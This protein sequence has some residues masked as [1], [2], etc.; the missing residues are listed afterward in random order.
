M[1]V[2]GVAPM[3][4][5]DEDI[6]ESVYSVIEQNFPDAVRPLPSI[7][8]PADAFDPARQQH[9]AP[10]ILKRLLQKV[11]KGIDKLIAVTD[12][13]LFIPMLSFVYGQAQLDGRVAAVSVTR[14]RQEFYDLPPNRS[15]LLAR[16]R[17][18]AAHEVGHLYGLVHCTTPQCAMTLSTNIRQIDLKGDALCHAC[19]VRIR[20]RIL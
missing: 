19:R 1:K 3:E 18:E 16:A 7:D 10:M 8:G 11:P 13:D 14:L 4:S 15:L 12:R 17:T 5:I 9:N 2:L 20:E 6:L